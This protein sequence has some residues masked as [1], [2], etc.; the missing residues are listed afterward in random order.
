MLGRKS[1]AGPQFAVLNHDPNLIHDLF[2]HQ[3]TAGRSDALKPCYFDRGH[4]TV[5]SG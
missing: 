2:C 1:I 5:L 3:A 4:T